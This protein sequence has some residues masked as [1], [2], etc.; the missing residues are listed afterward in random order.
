MRNLSKSKI[1]AFRQ[2]PKRLWLEIHQPELCD[3]SASEMVFQIGHE[4][5]EMA[6]D[7][8]D[9]HHTGTTISIEELGHSGA[10]ARSADL[11]AEGKAPIFEAGVAS[12]GAIAYADVMLPDHTDGTLRWKMIEIK[13]SSSVKDYY[14]E[15][16]AIQSYI[17]TSAGVRL[18]SVS[19]AH[20]DSSFVYQGNGDYRELLKENDLTE[21][22]L[23][24]SG[25]VQEWIAD[26]HAVA[27]LKAEP[28]TPTGLHCTKPFNCGFSNYCNRAKVRAQYPISTLPKLSK[29]QRTQFEAMGS[30]DLREIDDHLLSP[31]QQRVKKCAASGESYFDAEGAAATLNRHRFPA[32]FLDFETVAPAVPRWKDT[33]PYQKI[34]FQFSL[35]VLEENGTFRHH[36]FLDLSGNDPS[37]AC[38]QS[39]V[40]LCG[41]D[42]PV[43]AYNASFECSVMSKLASRFP[44]F[45]TTLESIISRVVD[46]LPIAREHYYHPSQHGSWSIKHVLPAAVPELSY[47]QLDG[48]QNGSL[49]IAA[50][51]E[52]IHPETTTDKKQQLEEQLNAYCKLDTW[53]MVRLWQFF[54]GAH[55]P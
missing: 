46:L 36:G 13:S 24:R 51:M 29:P 34:P 3:N 50:Y 1:I 11:L 31:I 54:T 28:Q 43:F 14:R 37:R 15:D 38:A 30:D 26:A 25:E 20:V 2:C 41:V 27:A 35:H 7:I 32:Y 10:L 4:V 55:L 53:A 39:L 40:D 49:A 5:G 19:I 17:A 52:A 9:P 45:A 6:R 22:A 8:H 12:N 48:V 44:E 18:S 42:G 21:E 47:D 23:G 16:I 33:S